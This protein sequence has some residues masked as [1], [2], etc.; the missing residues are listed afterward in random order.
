MWVWTLRLRGLM[1]LGLSSL[2]H[3]WTC[4]LLCSRSMLYYHRHPQWETFIA[5]VVSTGLSGFP[6]CWVC[7]EQIY[8]IKLFQRCRHRDTWGY[9]S[10]YTH[11]QRDSSL[12]RSASL[13]LHGST[14]AGTDALKQKLWLGHQNSKVRLRLYLSEAWRSLSLLINWDWSSCMVWFETQVS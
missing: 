11:R 9:E 1:N 3:L 8:Q 10:H 6:A 12:E 4:N 5:P 2:A 7:S 13:L 14:A